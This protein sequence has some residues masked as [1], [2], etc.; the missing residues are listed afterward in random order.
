MAESSGSLAFRE[1]GEEKDSAERKKGGPEDKKN[2][3]ENVGLEV[4]RGNPFRKKVVSSF[5]GVKSK[6]CILR[7]KSDCWIWQLRVT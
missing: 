4:N 3:E 2:Y 6:S 7:G 5:A 1:L